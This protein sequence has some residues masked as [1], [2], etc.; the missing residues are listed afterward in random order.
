MKRPRPLG[1]RLRSVGADEF[2]ETRRHHR[3]KRRRL[4]ARIAQTIAG[5]KIGEGFDKPVVDRRLHID[6]LD[7]AA[8]LTGIVEILDR[9]VE[10]RGPVKELEFSRSPRNRYISSVN[11]LPKV[12]IVDL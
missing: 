11:W 8:A 7:A 5:G 2:G 10:F 4:I 3:A 1:D 9:M 6:A 12:I